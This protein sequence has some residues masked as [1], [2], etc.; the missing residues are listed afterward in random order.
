[1]PV[2]DKNNS[3]ENS[4]SL[5]LVVIITITAMECVD[6]KYMNMIVIYRALTIAIL[7]LFTATSNLRLPR[8]ALEARWLDGHL[9]LRFPKRSVE[10]YTNSSND[11]DRNF[12]VNNNNS[13]N[14]H[15]NDNS[16]L[17]R[18]ALGGRSSEDTI[19]FSGLVCSLQFS[20]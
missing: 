16:S 19:S 15:N 3:S 4:P 7:P 6:N 1:M 13:N 12:Q 8:G 20:F 11:T 2:R 14:N 9:H 18:L 5:L 17:G 10:Q